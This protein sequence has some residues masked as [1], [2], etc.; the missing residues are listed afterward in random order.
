MDQPK[1]QELDLAAE[2][3]QGASLGQHQ[4]RREYELGHGAEADQGRPWATLPRVRG[5]DPG[6]TRDQEVLR[7][8][9]R[10]EGLKGSIVK[11]IL[12]NNN[13]DCNVDAKI[14]S[15]YTRDTL[16]WNMS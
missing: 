15:I 12:N 2:A 10:E 7:D 16:I 6:L 8:P 13:G 5:A 4:D 11:I 1:G 9:H 14:Y 3:G